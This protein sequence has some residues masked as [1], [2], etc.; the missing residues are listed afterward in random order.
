MT[1][2]NR[3]PV[4][5]FTLA[6]VSLVSLRRLGS[7]LFPCLLGVSCFPDASFFG[8]VLCSCRCVRPVFLCD[9]CTVVMGLHSPFLAFLLFVLCCFLCCFLPG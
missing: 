9:I 3:Q 2:G 5:L 7:L 6:V 8:I 1:F 4:S